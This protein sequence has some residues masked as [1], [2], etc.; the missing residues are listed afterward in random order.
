MSELTPVDWAL[1]PIKRYAQFSGRAPRAEYWWF[2]LATMVAGLVAEIVDGSLMS[3]EVGWLSL[4]VNL[5]LIV[6]S[7][8]V[9]VRRLH[10]TN[11]SGWWLFTVIVPAAFVGFLAIGAALEGTAES[12]SPTV[13]F[14]IA[15]ATTIIAAVA[16]FVFMVLPGTDGPNDFGDDPYGPNQLEEIFA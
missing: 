4:V 7:I 6:P 9:T 15:V 10:D 2:Y 13:P 14:V 3:N 16:L 5:A 12:F 8:A 11:R 1:R